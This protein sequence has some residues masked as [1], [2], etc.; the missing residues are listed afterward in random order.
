MSLV[1][2]PT[3]TYPVY[4]IIPEFLLR[5]RKPFDTSPT[6]LFAAKKFLGKHVH[7]LPFNWCKIG[8]IY[9]KWLMTGAYSRVFIKA[10]SSGTN[11][12]DDGPKTVSQFKI[13]QFNQNI[14]V[15]FLGSVIHMKYIQS[16]SNLNTFTLTNWNF[17]K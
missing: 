7:H 9:F 11:P 17:D 3:T 6:A 16:R 12:G 15:L 5:L 2:F 10:V 13:V 14:L 8:T 1:F 4:G